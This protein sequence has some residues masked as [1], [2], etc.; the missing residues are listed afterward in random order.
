MLTA[1]PYAETKEAAARKK[2]VFQEWCA[3]KGYEAAA[4][5]LDHDWERM[6]TFYRFP[7]EHW[8]HLRTTNPIESAFATVR[9][10]TT[11]SKG[12]LSNKTEEQLL[13]R[14]AYQRKLATGLVRSINDY[15]DLVAKA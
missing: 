8:K 14:S 11:R 5:V 4:Q 13:Q 12:C 10:R 2:R 7:K 6:T 15:F 3:K 9:H 1:I